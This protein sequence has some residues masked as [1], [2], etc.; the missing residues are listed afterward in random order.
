M[1]RDVTKVFGIGIQR[2][3]TTSLAAALRI[4]GYK[5]LDAPFVLYPDLDRAI[6]DEYDAFTDNPIPLFY[7]QLDQI[8]PGSKFIMTTRDMNAWL[9]SVKWLYST[10]GR[11]W[12]SKPLTARVHSDFYGVSEFDETIFKA[13]WRRYHEEVQA[14][15]A[16]RPQDL[17][18]IDFT[19]GEGWDE[20]CPF[21]D[22]P[23]PEEDFPARNQSSLLKTVRVRLTRPLWRYVRARI[24][25]LLG[26]RIVGYMKSV[27]DRKRV[28]KDPS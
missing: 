24:K 4:L 3:G 7:K 15:F 6:L 26:P 19:Q 8:F 10:F 5:V 21:L 14:Y 18:V 13:T 25:H 28:I 22:K 16:D 11:K 17:L 12:E 20:L 2:T 27:R 23:V 1:E 9:K